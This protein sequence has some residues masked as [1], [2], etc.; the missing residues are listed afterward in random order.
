MNLNLFTRY[1]LLYIILVSI[2][3]IFLMGYAIVIDTFDIIKIVILLAGFL[4][5]VITI[6]VYILYEKLLKIECYMEK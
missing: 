6:F 3:G 1:Q 2:S 5:A 4:T